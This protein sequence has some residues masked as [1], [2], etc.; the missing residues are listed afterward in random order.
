VT[1]HVNAVDNATWKFFIILILVLR[2]FTSK[3]P[4]GVDLIVSIPSTFFSICLF[5]CYNGQLSESSIF[6][7]KS[8]KKPES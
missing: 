6:S 7:V 8:T 5:K 4:F 2:Q 1:V 3:C